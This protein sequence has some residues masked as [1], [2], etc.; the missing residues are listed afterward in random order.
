MTTAT[1]ITVIYIVG[2]SRSGSTLIEDYIAR[3]FGGVAC[4]ELYRISQFAKGDARII[5]EDGAE[6]TC[7]C[8]APV[9]ECAF[10]CA[11]AEEAGLDLVQ[12]SFRSRLSRRQRVFFRLFVRLL[13]ARLTNRMGKL[14]PAFE[15][16]LEVGENCLRIYRAISRVANVSLI[17]DSSKQA[18][19]Y[20][21]L[22]AVAPKKM[23]LINL[24]RDGRSVVASMTKRARGEV[25][26]R[27]IMA[28]TGRSPAPE[29]VA[30]KAFRAWMLSTLNGLV[31]FAFTSRGRRAMLRYEEFFDDPKNEMS[32]IEHS[33]SLTKKNYAQ[34]SHA[35]G[36]SP[37]RYTVGFEDLRADASWKERTPPQK[38]SVV[39]VSAHLLN[40]ALGYR[41]V[42]RSEKN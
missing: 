23:R 25:L 11:V 26:A 4:G 5:K 16:E 31:A 28:G 29:D 6:E 20:Y 21:I 33:F 39:T 10:W 18:H 1:D 30:E 22:K 37:S 2:P 7:A 14:V 24:L 35:I 42:D 36:G 13:G 41:G 8:G 9:S 12:S 38:T 3:R 27:K 40:R 19:Q 15:R 34:E 17:V 32:R